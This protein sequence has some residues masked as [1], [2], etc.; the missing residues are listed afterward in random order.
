[1][2]DDGCMGEKELTEKIQRIGLSV[3]DK[4]HFGVPFRQPY[5][6]KDTYM[7]IE[8]IKKEVRPFAMARIGII[9]F[10]F[11]SILLTIDPRYKIHYLFSYKPSICYST[12]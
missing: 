8:D 2:S 6:D 4:I 9:F 12:F 5:P 1:M 7:Y 10:Y 11:N 3:Y